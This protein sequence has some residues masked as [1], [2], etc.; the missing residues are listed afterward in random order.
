MCSPHVVA[1]DNGSLLNG[2]FTSSFDLQN[3]KGFLGKENSLVY[4]WTNY[5]TLRYESGV[6]DTLTFYISMNIFALTG[7][8]AE[9][10]SQPLIVGLERLYLKT[11]NDWLGLEAGLIRIPRGYGYVFSPLDIFNTRNALDTL[12]P[13]GRPAGKWGG[14]ATFYPGDMWTIELFGLAPSNPLEKGPWGLKFGTAT[15]FSKD[16][17]SFDFLYSLAFPEIEYGTT[18]PLPYISNDFTHNAGFAL[19]A[20]IEIGLFAEALYKF[21]QKTLKEQKYYGEDY[22][23]YNGLEAALGV[24]Y[25][26]T[27]IDLYTSAEYLF[28]GPGYADWGESLDSLY[29]TGWQDIPPAFRFATLAAA[30]LPLRYLHHDY[31]FLL[32]RFTPE[33]DL[34]FGVSCLAGL[35]DLSCVTTSFCEYELFSGLTLQTSFILPI[36]RH[37]FDPTVEPGE[38]G[39]VS[40]GF[41]AM[42]RLGLK[43]KF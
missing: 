6:N 37:L 27:E 20:D 40:T 32:G 19:K 9:P 11:G 25:T 8:Y 12:D 21:D 15:T 31:L 17:V 36:D 38:L 18:P 14:H 33:Q 26:F 13:Q 7:F 4:G 39:S 35:D 42:A 1:Q 34:S 23:W 16:K 30:K 28:Y 2:S 5:A 24:D 41:F 43:M 22:K 10:P 3:A 29:G